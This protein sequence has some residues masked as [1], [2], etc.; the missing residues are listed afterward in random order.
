MRRLEVHRS[1]PELE[2][3]WSRV[4]TVRRRRAT[5]AA[6][7]RLF[8]SMNRGGRSDGLTR[9]KGVELKFEAFPCR[10]NV[11]GWVFSSG[12]DFL[13]PTLNSR[14]SKRFAQDS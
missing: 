4:E 3:L 2:A 11:V 1:M 8:P 5:L 12:H 13:F 7:P 14:G 10:P 6:L 9:S